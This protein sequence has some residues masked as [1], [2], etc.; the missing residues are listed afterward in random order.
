MS[1]P[2][3][4]KLKR[5]VNKFTSINHHKANTAEVGLHWVLDPAGNPADLAA[6][7]T[8]SENVDPEM[9]AEIKQYIAWI[10]AHPNRQ[11]GKNGTKWLQN[12]TH[13]AVKSFAQARLKKL[14]S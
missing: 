6:M 3:K 1:T 11:L 8:L 9:A 4:P 5:F 7:Y 14:G 2:T 10:E 12:I 13:P